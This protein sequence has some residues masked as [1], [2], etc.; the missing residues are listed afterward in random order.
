[1]LVRHACGEDEWAEDGCDHSTSDEQDVKAVLAAELVWD[2]VVDL[3]RVRV[4][5]RVKV[6]VRARVRVRV[7]VRVK[8]KVRV[9]VRED[10]VDLLGEH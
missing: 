7:R 10:I 9:R 4:R 1:L 5:A 8:V 2:D 6:R 3:V